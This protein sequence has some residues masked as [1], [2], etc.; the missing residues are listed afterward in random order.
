MLLI[1]NNAAINTGVQTSLP[2]ADSAAPEYMLKRGTT[3]PYGSSISS[4]GSFF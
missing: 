2:G 4:L 1:V 3:G